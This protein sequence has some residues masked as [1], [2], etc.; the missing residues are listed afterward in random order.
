M[1]GLCEGGNEPPG[2]LKASNWL[3]N[4]AVSTIRL[5][6][7]V[8]IGGREIVFGEMRP[9][10]SHRLPD[11][12]LTNGENL[13]KT[14]PSN[15]LKREL[16]PRPSAAPDWK[17]TP[18]QTE[19][20]RPITNLLHTLKA[21]LRCGGDRD[22]ED[23]DDDDDDD[24]GG[25]GGSG[26]GGGEL[27]G[28]HRGCVLLGP[29]VCSTHEFKRRYIGD[30][31]MIFG[32]ITPRIRHRLP[33]ICLTVGENIE[34]TH[35]YKISPTGIRIQARTQSQS[36]RKYVTAIHARE[37]TEPFKFPSL[38]FSTTQTLPS[39]AGEPTPSRHA[40]GTCS[41]IHPSFFP[42]PAPAP[43]SIPGTEPSARRG[44]DRRWAT[45]RGAARRSEAVDP[46]PGSILVSQNGIRVDEDDVG[47]D[48]LGVLPFPHQRL[49]N[50]PLIA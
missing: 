20:R 3:F 18:L 37:T 45:R 15:Q 27:L 13:G 8:G 1:A 39:I 4:D 35:P 16:N 14:Q 12:G 21:F 17:T 29:R 49:Y 46:D 5:F 25:G 9:R 7:I 34:E 19:L 50:L 23:D 26:G 24:D 32:D 48:L 33:D 36:E 31:E 41:A 44:A 47:I 22:E 6:S 38:S 28:C 30:S 40:A 2:S 11:I 10:I 43:K 42:L